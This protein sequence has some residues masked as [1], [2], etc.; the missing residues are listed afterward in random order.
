MARFKTGKKTTA[1]TR[2]RFSEGKVKG[3]SNNR[4]KSTQYP[5]IEGMLDAL[6]EKDKQAAKKR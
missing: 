2:V 6:I 3:N 1:A 4:V 5:E